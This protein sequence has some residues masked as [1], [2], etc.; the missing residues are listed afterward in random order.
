MACEVTRLWSPF[1]GELEARY[2]RTKDLKCVFQRKLKCPLP[3]W[4][5][6]LT[7]RAKRFVELGRRDVVEESRVVV[8]VEAANVGDVEEIEHFRNELNILLVGQNPPFGNT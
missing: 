3:T 1:Y 7:R 5:E 2:S 6:E 4:T 8:V